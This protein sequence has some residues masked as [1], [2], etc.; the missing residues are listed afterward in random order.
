MRIC[1]TATA[2]KDVKAEIIDTVQREL[3]L[4]VNQFEGGYERTNLH[5]EVYPVT[6]YEKFQVI[7]EILRA[8][9]TN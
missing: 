1:F 5:Y 3:G 8:R 6:K 4:R 9:F 2:K 7:L